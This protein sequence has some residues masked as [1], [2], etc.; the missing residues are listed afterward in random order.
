MNYNVHSEYAAPSCS[1]ELKTDIEKT[2]TLGGLTTIGSGASA[3]KY[4]LTS[5][6]LATSAGQAPTM[7]ASGVEVGSDTEEGCTC[8]VEF[9]AAFLHHAQ[10]LFSAFEL[11]NG[12]LQSANYTA[13]CEPTHAEADG[14]R[15]NSDAHGF[16]IEASVTIGAAGSTVPTLAAGTGWAITSPL[17][18]SNPN[19]DYPSYTATLTKYLAGTQPSSNS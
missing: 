16:K 7:S 15:L 11:S 1:Y 5:V 17:T 13:S 3:K 19:A 6:E 4:M 10:T 2:V 9:V 18:C 12:K 8:D 14:V